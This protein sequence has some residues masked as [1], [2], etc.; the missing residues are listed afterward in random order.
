MGYELIFKALVDSEGDRN[1]ARLTDDEMADFYANAPIEII[2]AL[3]EIL[4]FFNQLD[5]VAKME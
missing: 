4:R 1:K 5:R 3:N 2:E